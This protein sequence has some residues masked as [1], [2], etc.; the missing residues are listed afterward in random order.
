M[1]GFWGFIFLLL[2]GQNVNSQ[3]FILHGCYWNCPSKGDSTSIAFWNKHLRNQAKALSYAGFS[4]L[5]LPSADSQRMEWKELIKSLQDAGIEAI[6]DLKMPKE[7]A[8]S[9][10]LPGTEIFKTHPGTKGVRITSLGEPD[11]VV[12]ANFLNECRIQNKIPQI[13]YADIPEWQNATRLVAWVNK[14]SNALSGETREN[15]SL[16][17][18]D[19]ILREG[20]RRACD[21]PA[22]DVRQLFEKSL[23]DATTLTGYN[24]ITLVNGSKFQNQNDKKDDWDDPI[25]DPLLAY[26]YLLTNNQVGLPSVWYEDYFGNASQT[27]LKNEIDRLIRVH[28][29]YI[30][31]S[32]SIEYLNS[33]D[34]DHKSFYLSAS[35][36]AD[37]TQALI[38][39]LNGMHTSAGQATK[40]HRDVIVAINFSGKPLKVLQEINMSNVRIEDVFTDILG[41]SNQTST[42]IAYDSVH[43]I[44]NAIFLD[45]PA[46]SYS[47][48]VQG[49]A[50]PVA[51]NLFAL[52]VEP[53]DTYA[54]LSWEVP[55]GIGNRGYEIQR[56]VNS[57]EFNQIGEVEAVDEKESGA[58][59]LYLDEERFPDDEVLYRIRA[60]EKDGTF[61]YSDVVSIRPFAKAMTFEVTNCEQKGVK[62]LK[63]KS[64][65]EDEGTLTVY[66]A[67]GD[68]I[69][70]KKQH[71]RRGVTAVKLDLSKAPSGVYLVKISTTRKKDWT[72]K[73][74]N[75]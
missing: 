75:L 65:F 50:N 18:A 7:D 48:W 31:N 5:W 55:A 45:L 10:P 72:K 1:K 59:Y 37:A 66:N 57:H 24:T 30:F 74:L 12:L 51:N 61:T 17:V 71:I 2:I 34:T 36:G 23:R 29:E 19:Y 63:I 9:Q 16:R 69:L 53:F 8:I 21:D 4:Y 52:K 47:V 40:G 22:Y 39:Q 49:E 41:R 64:N 38:F 3:D 6:A 44:P 33:K 27:P 13:V 42:V 60:S 25:A 46:R 28:K 67:N 58:S 68:L 26:A 56:A 35:D 11:P 43:H 20:L 15:V 62:S 14:I 73:V 70:S 32:T 54:E